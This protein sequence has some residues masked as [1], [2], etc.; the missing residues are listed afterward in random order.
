MPPAR[1]DAS[2]RR[3]GGPV[4]VG[5]P[6]RNRE[7]QGFKISPPGTRTD[8]QRTRIASPTAADST[9]QPALFEFEEPLPDDDVSSEAVLPEEEAA[10]SPVAAT[11][12][13]AGSGAEGALRSTRSD[14]LEA[15]LVDL[16]SQ[17]RRN[18]GQHADAQDCLFDPTGIAALDARLGGGFPRGRLSEICGP[19]SSGR[20]SIALSL[21]AETL[22]RGVLAAWIDLADAFDPVSAAAS[23]QVHHRDANLNR[24]LWV[25]ARTEDE[26]LRSCDRLLQTEGFELLVFD[27]PLFDPRLLDPQGRPKK[28]GT[29]I[30]DV[31]WLRLAR[32]ANRTRTSLVV[33]SEHARA[34]SQSSAPQNGLGQS[35]TGSRADL[36]LEM[37]PQ[38]ARFTGSPPLL[39]S[40]E[41]NAVLRRHRSRPIGQEVPLSIDAESEL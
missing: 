21:L 28:K 9:T 19:A 18:A 1:P 29:G 36:V 40:L 20:T 10:E 6:R 27:L 17:V 33:I 31:S 7:A 3:A 5:A 12:G 37:R 24:L 11:H 25:R 35:V 23:L 30:R 4:G 2:V 16:G 38:G 39:R 34:S 32:L 15:L 22:A 8:S 14:A 26:A 41:T 13:G